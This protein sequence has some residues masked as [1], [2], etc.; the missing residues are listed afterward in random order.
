MHA[1]TTKIDGFEHPKS[2][3]LGSTDAVQNGYYGVVEVL[4]MPSRSRSPAWEC[5][6]HIPCGG[7]LQRCLGCQYLLIMSTSC[8]HHVIKSCVLDTSLDALIHAIHG[9]E[10]C[11]STLLDTCST[12]YTSVMVY[13]YTYTPC[14]V[15]HCMHV[16]LVCM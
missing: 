15:Y 8:A 3:I 11:I 6:M 7:G 4:G 12:P 1:K 9:V 5:S 13:T 14:T 2:M 10:V 16:L